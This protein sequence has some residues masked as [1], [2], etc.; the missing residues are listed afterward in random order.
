VLLSLHPTS[1][2]E[3]HPL[4]VMFSSLFSILHNYLPYLE[5]ISSICKTCMLINI[6]YLKMLKVV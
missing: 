4:S 1:K 5:A 2:L 3:D 6:F